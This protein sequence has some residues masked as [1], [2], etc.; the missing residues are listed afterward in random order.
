MAALGAV[1]AGMVS[2]CHFRRDTANATYVGENFVVYADSCVQDEYVARALSDTLLRSNFPVQDSVRF[3]A[4][5]PVPG[6][7]RYR[8]KAPLNDA[9][10]NMSMEHL[11]RE[12][13]PRSTLRTAVAVE[14]ALAYVN[15]EKSK[16]LL[17]AR[18]R[19]GE[20]LQGYAPGGGWPV[21]ADGIAWVSAAWS[22][23][24]VTGDRRWL[25]EIYP[26][27]KST[28]ERYEHVSYQPLSGL[29]SGSVASLGF[30]GKAPYPDWMT[31]ADR[32]ASEPLSVNALVQRAYRVCADMAEAM[33]DSPSSFDAKADSLADA[34]N[35][36][37][38][39]PN[40]SRYGQ[41][42][43]GHPYP[44][45]SFTSDNLATGWCMTYD[46]ATPEMRTAILEN[47][48]MS[49]AGVP[50]VY[51][52][53][54]DSMLNP[55]DALVPAVQAYWGVASA[56]AGNR[57]MLYRTLYS[58]VNES[59]MNLGNFPYVN[60]NDGIP[61][62]NIKRQSS[63]AVSAAANIAVFYRGLLGFR[64]S[65]EGMEIQPLIAPTPD[66][67]RRVTN[68]RYRDAVL[69][70][71]VKGAGSM[72]S[73]FKLDSVEVGTRV[74]PANLS[75]HHSVEIMMAG[76]NVTPSKVT[77][78][79]Q[80]A[81][82]PH[83]P[84]VK[85]KGL[86]G[87]ITNF[88]EGEAYEVFLNGVLQ[89]QV[90]TSTYKMIKPK[91]FMTVSLV[92]VKEESELGYSSRPTFFYPEGT[93]Y[94]IPADSLAYTGTSLIPDRKVASKFVETTESFRSRMT[95]TLDVD[96]E[97]AY[98]LR[99]VYANGWADADAGSDFCALRLVEINGIVQGMLVMPPV[100]KDDWT[101][102]AQSNML[103]IHLDKGPNRI[104]IVYRRPWTVNGHVSLN[105]ALIE[106]L[107]IY[108][109][110]D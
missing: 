6:T 91:E 86:E 36:Q 69:D 66:D 58:L 64:F 54:P 8:S 34:I 50:T 84:E 109:L 110:P 94:I 51:P 72:V 1:M 33:G 44:I 57:T 23:Y 63:D 97:G 71:S 100:K 96:H 30:I 88:I 35:T 24:E 46:I 25:K 102:T 22:V 77:V 70:I 16:E 60:I 13:T 9:V 98:L 67:E 43:Y 28:L 48:P 20:I 93:Q 27:A 74:I 41:Y 76:N 78:A 32:G 4:V 18:L 17:R 11:G 52:Q 103:R 90:F 10:L 82:M 45:V 108:R 2:S 107:Q 99:S 49:A 62:A 87:N 7:M 92:P 3:L 75:G 65:R 101:A 37:L 21:A 29:F 55:S 106:S 83:T 42:R 5:T 19:D 12:L 61:P 105:T 56:L 14:L 53:L 81:R 73:S 38:W 26:I 40:L 104:S 85:W 47:T 31:Q 79:K 39:L 59:A 15:P 95:A 80:A 89:E 68:F